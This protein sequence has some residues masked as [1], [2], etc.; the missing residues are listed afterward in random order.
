VAA[1]GKSGGWLA[2]EP[3][4][5]EGK[6]GGWLAGEPEAAEGKS[7]GWLAGEPEA[8]EAHPRLISETRDHLVIVR[9]NP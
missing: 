9:L 7:G 8:A 4:A 6:S 1:E 2:G 3:E 5:A